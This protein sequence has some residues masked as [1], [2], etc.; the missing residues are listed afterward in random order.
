MR[1]AANL[2]LEP[3]IGALLADFASPKSPAF[4]LPPIPWAIA[5]KKSRYWIALCDQGNG[6]EI[7]KCRGNEANLDYLYAGFGVAA[8]SA[9]GR[10][11]PSTSK[12]SGG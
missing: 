2:A 8:R 1:L 7:L 9:A 10:M 4:S 6:F 5:A 12:A 3:V 11:I